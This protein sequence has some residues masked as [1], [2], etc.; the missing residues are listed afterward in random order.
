MSLEHAIRVLLRQCPTVSDAKG[1]Y[2]SIAMGSRGDNTMTRTWWSILSIAGCLVVGMG[3]IG[4]A[5]TDRQRIQALE[6]DVAALKK[7]VGQ[8]AAF[9]KVFI[10]DSG[11]PLVEIRGANLRIVNGAGNTETANGLGNL[12][13]GYNEVR[14]PDETGNRNTVRTGSH[15]II[16]GRSINYEG[17]ASI[18]V[19]D[20]HN[21]HGPFTAAIAGSSH[22]AQ[23]YGDAVFG[24][25]GNVAAGGFAAVC[26][27]AVTKAVHSYATVSGGDSNTASG[28][29]ASVSGGSA[30]EAQGEKFT[31][32][33]VS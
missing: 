20:Q 14:P 9:I 32:N 8:Y 29:A 26:G 4:E 13:V 17:V 30:N 5:Q 25:Q 12:I 2:R 10:D 6:R 23:H 31:V 28:I 24:G 19:G 7:V 21:L 27:G 3:H 1:G 16:A 33:D 15:N 11:R 22:T 18:A